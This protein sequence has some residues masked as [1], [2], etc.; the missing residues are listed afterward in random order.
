MERLGPCLHDRSEVLIAGV[1][2]ALRYGGQSERLFE[3][4][5]GS[6]DGHNSEER[7]WRCLAG[8]HAIGMDV[9]VVHWCWLSNITIVV[10]NH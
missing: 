4:C 7:V 5:R 9:G 8:D 6:D 2:R 10:V 3:L 1:E